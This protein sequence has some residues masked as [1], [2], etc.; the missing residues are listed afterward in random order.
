M[1]IPVKK[2]DKRDKN[3]RKLQALLRDL[4]QFDHAA[5]DFGVYRIM[6]EKRDEVE[7]F[8]EQ[9]LLE[10]VEEALALFQE[11]DHEDG[12]TLITEEAE[13][14]IFNDLWRFFSR[15]YDQG[16]F[17]TER[18]YSSYGAK[19]CVPYNGQE[20][21]L[22]WAN[23]DQ[24]YVKTGEHFTDYHFTTAPSPESGFVYNIWFR[25]QRAATPQ[26]NVKGDERY[27]VLRENEPLN[28]DPSSRTLIVHFEYRPITEAE[29]AHYLE[30]YN[31]WPS[32]SERKR[33][34][35]SV[36]V[37][38]LSTEIIELLQERKA[39]DLARHLAASPDDAAALTSPPLLDVHLDRYTARHTMDYF[40][41]KDLGHFLRRE[42]DVFLKEE[43]M[44]LDDLLTGDSDEAAS[45][46]SMASRVLLRIRIV[47]RIAHRVIDFLAQIEDFQKRLFEK[48]K[49]VVRT[50]Y[51]ITLDQ[52]PESL[53]PEILANEAQL[54]KWLW[55]YGMK[56]WRGK[57]SWRGKFDMAFLKNHPSLMIDTAFFDEDF[58]ARLLATFEDLDG[59]IDGVLMQGENLQ[60]LNLMM[61]KYRE[62][63]KCIYIDPPYN[64]GSDDF[65]YKDN[66]RRSSWLTMMDDR[67][68]MGR[69][70]LH[71]SGGYFISIDYNQ[72][73]E[74]RTYLDQAFGPGCYRN[75]ILF[76]RGVK[77][78][79]AQFDTI[80]A[81]TRGYEYVLFYA[82]RSEARFRNLFKELDEE[83]PGS[84]NSH[85]RGTD[86]PTMRYEL[87]G[88]EPAS[89]QWRWS[90]ARSQRAIENYNKLVAQFRREGKPL[91]DENIDGWY[92]E[93][94]EESKQSRIDLLRYN[95]KNDT[96]EHYVPP[97]TE[98]ML[99]DV[100][101]DLS[102][103]GSR[104]LKALFGHKVHDNPK[105]VPLIKRA[106]RFVTNQA[107]LVLDFFAGSGTTAHAV[108]ELN[109]EGA[110][111]GSAQAGG[112]R[113]YVLV[114][115]DAYSCSVIKS[116]IQ[117][118]AF[119]ANWR[120]GVPQD[121]EGMGH[122]IKYQRV[123]SYEDAL[124]NIK[125]EKPT[126]ASQEMLNQFDDYML[127]YMLDFETRGSPTLLNVEEFERPFDYTLKIQHDH[128]SPT[129]TAVDLVETFHYLIGMHVRR[130]ERHEHQGRTYV[131]SRGDV[132]T[133]R[134][135]ERVVVI[136]R[137]LDD[138]DIKREADW[139]ERE[140]LAEPVDRVYANGYKN[141]IQG[142][143][144]T[145]ITFRKRMEA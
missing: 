3:R 53:Y 110:A 82:K 25:L 50:D 135:V 138:L 124:N 7:R 28:Y 105:P 63:V 87:F 15:Y 24:Y 5:L 129:K 70:F 140:L 68:Q 144:P 89:G 6:N 79:Q 102:P 141:Y 61:S 99:N 142:A 27:F 54:E 81:L 125:I 136:W 72:M 26:D 14:R 109:R 20:V 92:Q 97:R 42:L 11:T 95:E 145:S 56:R 86:R 108:M 73:P 80:E 39:M 117:K 4:F 8:I 121:C 75:T 120:D 113:K 130:M 31:S 132:R 13:A 65:V 49:F 128:E 137:D 48:R 17:L 62:R 112:K 114:E 44:R 93:Q 139:V 52:V 115:M 84:W 47:R 119:S 22:H 111:T 88:I 12:E 116:R 100:W 96:V 103:Y 126:G 57:L 104:T 74:L 10:A 18:R 83:K 98:R 41:H 69:E 37:L 1:K 35:R 58:K 29:E 2:E 122:M 101:F 90:E 16:D 91:T 23:R 118:V 64:T 107:D 38:A 94:I 127:H 33:L 131:V 123:E 34:D 19:Y 71:D 32:T 67:L 76:R 45:Y 106:V 134:G 78:V 60:A 43:V 77:S 51:C 133:G 66:Y 21:M 55:L 59:A 30:L 36:L 85:W 46:P 143:E 40:V 9:E